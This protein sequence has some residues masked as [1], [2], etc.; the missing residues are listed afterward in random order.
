MLT[1]TR[2]GLALVFLLACGG[3]SSSSPRDTGGPILGSPN[4]DDD[5][6]EDTCVDKDGDG[7]GLGCPAGLDC[8]DNDDTVFEDCKNC[9]KPNT[10][11]KC[12]ADSAPLDCVVPPEEVPEGA[13]FCK[14]GKR[15]CRDGVWTKCIGIAVYAK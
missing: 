14:G 15:Y 6:N 12:E 10:G 3:D 13:L 1:R 2:L 8:D 5:D 4:G 7:Y 11:C 9:S